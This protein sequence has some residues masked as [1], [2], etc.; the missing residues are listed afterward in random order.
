MT[1]ALEYVRDGIGQRGFIQSI[2]EAVAPAVLA[3]RGFPGDWLE[4]A[5]AQNV[6]QNVKAITVASKIFR[7]PST[8][9]KYK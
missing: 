4:N 3:A 9:A 8:P 1:A 6:A 2:V 7:S 5:I